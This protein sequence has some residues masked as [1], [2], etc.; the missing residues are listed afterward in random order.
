MNGLSGL[1][2]QRLLLSLMLAGGLL[3]APFSL[4]ADNLSALINQGNLAAEKQDYG[5]AIQAYEQAVKQAP[6][7]KVLKNNLAVLYANHAVGLQEQKKYDAAL[8][9]LDKAAALV[10]TGSREEKSVQGAR[11]SVYFSKAMDLKDAAEKPTAADY[12]R[13]RGLLDKAITLSPNE[14]A[15]K[16]GMAG[17]YQDEAYQLAIREQFADAIPLLEKALTYDANNKTVKQSLANVYLGMARNEPDNRKSWIDKA[18]AM[19]NSPKIQQVADKLTAL[20]AM[21]DPAASGGFAATPNEAGNQL[22]KVASQLSVAE[23]VRDMEA[24][25]QITPE[26]NATLN[27]RLEMLEKQVLGKTQDGALATRTKTVYAS[28][29][30]SYDGTL[31]QSNINLRQAP[32]GDS[33]NSY[34]DEIFKVTDGK[35]VRWGKFPLRVYFEEPGEE[36]PLPLYKAEYKDA[37]LKGFETWKDRTDGYVKFLEVKNPQAADIIVNWT[38]AYVDR[39]ADPEAVSA[40]YQKYTP[41][42]RSPLMTAV[43]VASAFT[44]G[45]FS[46]LPQAAAAGLQYQQYKKMAVIQE[47]SKIYLGLDPTRELKPEAA[48]LLIQNMAAKEFG[49]ALGLKGTS[50]QQ[51]DLL[52]PELRSDIVQV[53]SNRDLTTLRELYNRPPN[54]ILNVR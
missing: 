30:G 21:P 23:M 12:E 42:K 29:M 4:A 20:G 8:S 40:I 25:L 45:Y 2:P 36:N 33:K 9:N 49:H 47:E 15:F 6:D 13:M 44:P 11:A 52:Y 28:L 22:P 43:Q 34:L 3:S 51:G 24:Q 38:E 48:A 5:A 10:T 53:P 1:R 32:S 19:D 37:A 31:A 26:K 16:K 17:V 50:P 14:L 39:Y 35:V 46:L 27:Q 7:Q 18:L 54:I 41:P